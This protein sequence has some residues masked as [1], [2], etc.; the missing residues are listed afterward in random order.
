MK[1]EIVIFHSIGASSHFTGLFKVAK[2]KGYKVK[3]RKYM[4]L[5]S[6]LKSIIRFSPKEFIDSLSDIF[7]YL[8]TILGIKS[9]QKIIISIAPFDWRIIFMVAIPHNNEI[10][11]HNSWCRWN[12]SDGYSNFPYKPLNSVVISFWKIFFKKVKICFFVTQ[13]ALD[14]FSQNF[15]KHENMRVVYHCFD[16][17]IFQYNGEHKK[18]VACY[19]GRLEASKGLKTFLNIASIN[20]KYKFIVAGKGSYEK[21]CINTNDVNYLGF[22]NQKELSNIF[23]SSDFLLLPSKE[24]SNW[25]ESF[26]IVVIQS[27]ACGVI[28]ISTDN[29]GPKEIL[30]NFQN[31]LITEDNF[32]K[33]ANDLI[34]NLTEENKN[35]LRM[36][37]MEEAKKYTTKNIA[38]R[39][40]E[41]FHD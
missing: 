26:G 17:T 36:G 30:K 20:S 2:R 5:R 9:N 18:Q 7:W 25:H 35:I 14:S 41:I 6:L 39:W 15:I 40:E 13:T 19:A 1:K 27:M 3:E 24:S 22:L 29:P 34:L 31:L 16:E 38:L 8:Q 32:E 28:P 37:L 21:K 4:F 10:Y 11:F 12:Q 23:I 33:H